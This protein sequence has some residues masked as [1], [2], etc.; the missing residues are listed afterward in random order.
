MGTVLDSS[1]SNR[2]DYIHVESFSADNHKNKKYIF[3]ISFRC[4]QTKFTVAHAIDEKW[5]KITP[6][7]I[8]CIIDT[9]V[10]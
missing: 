2:C 7:Q 5:Q 1:G 6:E 4:N 10:D 9:M 3:I 8:L